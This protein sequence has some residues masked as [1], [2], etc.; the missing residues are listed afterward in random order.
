MTLSVFICE[1]DHVQRKNIEDV[2]TSHADKKN[3]DV[4]IVLSTNNPT[5]LAGYLAKNTVQNSFYILDVDLQHEING[6]AL[7]KEIREHDLD[8]I[9]VFVTTHMEL[10]H[11]TFKYRVE[12]MDYIIKA[13]SMMKEV[14][15]CLDLAYNRYLAALSEDEYFQVKSTVGLQRIPV[16]RIMYIEANHAVSNKLTLHTLNDR[17]EFR[18]T[19]KDIETVNPSF[20]RCNK[21]Y[22]INTKNIKRVQRIQKIGEA[23][24]KNGK[25]VPIGEPKIAALLKIMEEQ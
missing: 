17:V 8:G 1:D 9:I 18:G 13:D 19:L 22:I 24:M 14:C 2:I 11:M 25:I 4:N 20:F 16:D 12:A 3:Y 5:K 21:S 23:E 10:T 6:I 15:E 7:A